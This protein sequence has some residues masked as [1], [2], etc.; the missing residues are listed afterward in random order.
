[1]RPLS[2]VALHY[3]QYCVQPRRTVLGRHQWKA[4]EKRT[5]Q[6]DQELGLF[7]EQK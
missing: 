2:K 6:T 1:M 5:S 3:L 4:E 7:Y